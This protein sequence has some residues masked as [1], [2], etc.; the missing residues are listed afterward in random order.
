MPTDA[1]ANFH[2]GIEATLA[3]PD[4]TQRQWDLGKKVRA[5][6]AAKG[7]VSV[8]APGFEAPGVV[9]VHT[10]DV[11]A[12]GKFAGV[13]VQIAAGVPLMVDHDT[14]TQSDKFRTFRFGLFGLDKLK[15]VDACVERLKN[16]VDTAML[17]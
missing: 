17:N 11:G 13:G 5:M 3:L 1:I 14:N 9:V 6:L 2:A 8:A 7:F 12:P 4:I 15:D 16:A 10:T